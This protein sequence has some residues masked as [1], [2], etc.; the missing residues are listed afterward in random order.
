MAI[1]CTEST[2]IWNC[3]YCAENI[4]SYL[5][6][7]LQPLDE[8]MKTYIKD[9]NYLLNKVKRFGKIYPGVFLCTINVVDIY[10]NISNNEVLDSLWR[11]IELKGNSS[12]EIEG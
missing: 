10:P 7:H 8:K 6:Y 9:A 12:T 2:L 1:W 4:S 11:F 3:S 5:D